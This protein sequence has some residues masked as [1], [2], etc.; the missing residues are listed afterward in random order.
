[1]AD[2]SKKRLNGRADAW[3]VKPVRTLILLLSLGVL[4]ACSNNFVYNQLDWLIPWYV[5]DYVDLTRDQKRDLKS[6]L[7]P[8][9]RWHRS[10]ELASYIAI[11]D[12]IED[13]LQQPVSAATIES[14]ANQTLLAWEHLQARI[15]PL[16]LDLGDQLSAEQ[17][18]E[19][20]AGLVGDQ[21]ELEEEY[22][23]R[24]D[25]E[26][27]AE[28][29]ES[30]TDNLRDFLGPLT[31]Q[32]LQI[33]EAASGS[34][35]RFDRL[36]LEDRRQWLERLE[37]LLQRE[38][39]WREAVQQALDVRDSGHDPSYLAVYEHNALIINGAIAETLNARTDKQSRRLQ[40]EM[41][42]LRRDLRK[43]IEQGN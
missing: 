10:E 12:A 38:P 20:Q 37:V 18:Q 17:M 25:A 24:S 2:K 40:R 31:D 28:T 43:M 29:L 34:L 8:M 1:M 4:S 27:V 42:D 39:G 14:W 6:Q 5:D 16:A 30:F 3:A 19:F 7:Q 26:V 13:D 21:L 22:L 9:L 36:W 15:L 32:Q 41:D 23:G 11:I 35:L 33:L